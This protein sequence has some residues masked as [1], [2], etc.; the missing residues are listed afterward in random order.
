MER[1]SQNFAVY[2][3]LIQMKPLA[4]NQKPPYLMVHITSLTT[5]RYVWVPFSLISQLHPMALSDVEELSQ[6]SLHF[7]SGLLFHVLPQ[8][9]LG[10]QVNWKK[11][12]V[13]YGNCHIHFAGLAEHSN[14]K[15]CM[16]WFVLVIKRKS[17][18]AR[19]FQ[20]IWE[21]KGGDHSEETNSWTEVPLEAPGSKLLTW[22]LTLQLELK[23]QSGKAPPSRESSKWVCLQRL[24]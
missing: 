9:P 20:G 22:K 3:L 21:A 6:T 15:A 7:S 1:E 4:S 24:S 2:L 16:G 12:S 17:W 10:R 11:G 5:V 23:I 13:F 8:S 14:E 19:E 18:W